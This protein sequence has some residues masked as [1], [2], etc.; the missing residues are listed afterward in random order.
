M[1]R[2]DIFCAY[3]P[4]TTWKEAHIKAQPILRDL[5][6]T[7]GGYTIVPG[8]GG[9]VDDG[10][11]LVIDF[12]FMVTTWGKDVETAIECACARLREQF[13]QDSV[14]AISSSVGTVMSVY[15]NGVEKK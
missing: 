13:K 9:W 3:P 10:G 12:S 8:N 15:P 2:W 4:S 11:K 5:A 7:T 14:I 6:R 1:K